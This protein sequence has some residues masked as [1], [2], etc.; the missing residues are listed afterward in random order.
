MDFK[1]KV[2]IITGAAQGIGK[3]MAETFRNHNAKVYD[4]DIQPGCFV[5]GDISDTAVIDKFVKEIIN[6][7]HSIDFIINN[8]LPIMKGIHTCSIEEFNYALQVGVSAPFYLIQ[9][10]IPY[11]NNNASI[12][13]ISSTR[14]HMSQP[15]TESYAAAKGGISALT[16]A[17]AISLRDKARVNAILPG[18]ID[19]SGTEF[20]GA[21]SKQHPAGRVG[22]PG[23]IT[24][25]VLYLCSEHASFI[26][27][28]EIVIDGGM[29]KQMIYHNDQGWLFN[30]Y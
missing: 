16:H 2:V 4:I 14:A 27:G 7:N 30:E 15:E 5:Q 21:N 22:V 1:N 11:L 3:H 10:L 26:T 19:T 23:D 12:V 17:L 25:M 20:T 9:Q 29:S 18:W 13:N 8:A 6:E 24:Q 28:Q